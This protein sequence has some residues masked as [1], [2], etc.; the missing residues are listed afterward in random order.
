MLV[1]QVPVPTEPDVSIGITIITVPVRLASKERTAAMTLTSAAS[2]VFASMVEPA[3]T[4]MGPSAVSASQ[5]TAGAHVRCPP[6]P[7]HHLSALMGA[8][9]DRPAIIP[10]SVLAY[11][12]EFLFSRAVEHTQ[13]HSRSTA[14]GIRF[15]QPDDVAVSAA[16]G[17]LYP[18]SYVSF[19]SALNSF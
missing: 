4:S 9:V 1:R 14:T 11:Q 16:A 13:T 8:H 6:C 5:A 18:L 15:S 17:V 12:V 2:L 3:W 7:V 10:M 19:L